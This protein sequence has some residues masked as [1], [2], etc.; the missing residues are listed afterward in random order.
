[1][2]KLVVFTALIG[3]AIADYTVSVTEGETCGHSGSA[4][5]SSYSYGG[6]TYVCKSECPRGYKV[7]N[8]TPVYNG[9]SL[10][11]SAFDLGVFPCPT[12]SG[13]PLITRAGNIGCYLALP[14]DQVSVVSAWSFHVTLT[15]DTG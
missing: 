10:L 5:L 6:R 3:A 2:L 11:R 1:M 8:G 14:N 13:T 4:S 15:S 12:I 9:T 7:S